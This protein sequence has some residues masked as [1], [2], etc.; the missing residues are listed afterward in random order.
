M[1]NSSHSPSRNKNEQSLPPRQGQTFFWL[2]LLPVFLIALFS[3]F[4]NLWSL[5]TLGKEN[6]RRLDVAERDFVL[7]SETSQ[8]EQQ[9]VTVNQVAAEGL[10][11]AAKG[12]MDE[13]ELYRRHS[14]I[15]DNLADLAEQVELL[16]ED[17]TAVITTP[18]SPQAMITSYEQ[19]RNFIIMATDIASIDPHQAKYYI[20][21]AQLLFME[22]LTQRQNISATLIDHANTQ[23][24]VNK[25]S[26]ND[27]VN[28]LMWW[29]FLLLVLMLLISITVS[30]IVSSRLGKVV[31]SLAL[32]AQTKGTPLPLPDMI[33]MQQ[34]G[35]GEFKEMA[36]ATLAFHK[37]LQERC[38]VEKQ[39]RTYQENL[40]GVV[41][42][43]TTEL[44]RYI[45]AIDDL[46]IGL[47]VIDSDYRTH[48]R[49]T[50]LIDWFGDRGDQPCY[51][52]IM[53][54][55]SQCSFCKLTEVL[56][57]KKKTHYQIKR[58]D[59][60]VFEIVATPIA[61]SDGT[62]SCMEIIRDITEQ[63][64]LEMQRLETSR[65]V[66]ELKKLT[67]LRTMAGAIAHRFNNAMT[68]VLGNLDMLNAV[69]QK[70]SDEQ[71]MASE[72][73]QAARG[74]SQ[75]GSRMLDYV[76]QHSSNL[77]RHSLPE[78]VKECLFP[79]K[80]HLPSSISLQFMSSDQSLDCSVDQQQIK[81]TIKNIV[82]NSIE[83]LEDH[84]GTIQV[85]FGRDFF[86]VDSFPIV[87]RNDDVKD[88]Q[89]VF[90]QIQDSGHGISPDNLPRIF[91]PFYSTKFV[92]RGLGLALIVGFMQTHHGA[93]LV[94]STVGKGTT[95]RVL[96]PV[97][98]NT[99]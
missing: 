48:T 14:A 28:R 53:E 57:Q 18:E 98:P 51:N 39:L 75:I 21:E 17:L 95:T 92:G 4:L 50:T 49:N 38:E 6:S 26:Y 41:A 2:F 16:V 77:E 42:R 12:L 79:I 52:V 85:T 64:E 11:K 27:V 13:A 96:L 74:A 25:Q 67:S 87:F 97:R 36:S 55:G 23:H 90:C 99:P 89:Y 76:G 86:T 94:E 72:A 34:K 80:A 54:Q 32:L 15:V 24:S 66:E 47:C 70:G 35:I 58:Q 5:N 84:A 37:A 73:A 43:R 1:S 22:M 91:E 59:G 81:E 3:A 7:L 29:T 45:T 60:R 8:L 78:L 19:Y 30:K 83:S 61:N 93:I 71:Q 68:A 62:T 46:G 9:M 20:N 44:Q 82:D 88:G 40:E 33:Q 31:R 56:E 63:E 65:Q 10:V 69:L